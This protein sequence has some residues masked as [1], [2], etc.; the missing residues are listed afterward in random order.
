M[1]KWALSQ[2]CKDSPFSSFKIFMKT[3]WP[4]VSVLSTGDPVVG[5]IG[6]APT[7]M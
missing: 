7:L 3:L 4:P 2:G 6:K 5:N 1:T